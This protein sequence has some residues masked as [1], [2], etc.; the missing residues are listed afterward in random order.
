[1]EQISTAHRAIPL[2]CIDKGRNPRTHF[3][4]AEMAELVD[5]VRANGIVQPILVRPVGEGRFEIIA[6]ERRVR[7]STIVFGDQWE[8]PAMV[9][10]CGDEEADRLALVENVDRAD[11]AATEEAAA[12]QRLLMRFKGDRIEAA[13]AL[14]WP[15]SKMSRRLALNNLTPEVQD[16]LNRRI[17][18]LGHAELLA[19]VVMDKQNSALA[20]ILEHDLTIAQVKAQVAT[21]TNDLSAAVFDKTECADCRFNSA[22][23]RALFGEAVADGSCTNGACFT[24]KTEA[25]LE[26]LRVSM[27][28]EA[29]KVIILRQDSGIEPI[30]LVADGK[31]GVG[32]EQAKA[33]RSCE[34][35][36]CTVS[37]VV[38]SVGSVER[39]ICFDAGCHSTKVA[40]NIK[41]ALDSANM[42]AKE[43]VAGTTGEAQGA[44]TGKEGKTKGVA[45]VKKPKVSV[46][47]P[48]RVKDFRLAKWRLMAAKDVFLNRERA[49]VIL[50]GLALSGNA[51]HINSAKVM[52]VLDA[53]TKTKHGGIGFTHSLAKAAAVAESHGPEIALRL[54]HAMAASAF[55]EIEERQLRDAMTF[56]GVKVSSHWKLDHEFMSLLTKS[57]IEA[58]A[59]ELGL[60]AT[61]GEKEFKKAL[62]GKKDDTIKRLLAVEGFDYSNAVPQVMQ[63]AEATAAEDDAGSEQ[64]EAG[65]DGKGADDAVV[66]AGEDTEETQ[67]TAEEAVLEGQQQ[68]AVAA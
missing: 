17:I 24:E 33:C 49:L 15:M 42:A 59:E 1:M 14:G 30:R 39:N 44:A 20:K 26:V 4:E 57:E 36:G 11:M 45:K 62:T 23:Q 3:D 63:Y 21:L 25:H 19:A 5:S 58:L 53:I 22:Q 7:A 61:L 37:A 29:P 43:A 35:F 52:E 68:T 28:D 9:R 65:A 56:L 67:A 41:A 2:G 31:L 38:G 18:K 10:D 48:Q 60:A 46:G 50:V 32:V 51:R 12:A 66:V 6:G 8:I 64:E 34:N 27:L 13:A 47:V 54:A 40:V 55:K 16:A